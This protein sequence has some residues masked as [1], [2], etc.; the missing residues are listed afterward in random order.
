MFTI[1]TLLRLHVLDRVYNGKHGTINLLTSIQSSAPPSPVQIAR[2]QAAMEEA[3]RS[4]Q[5]ERSRFEADAKAMQAR[6]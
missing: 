6:S 2:Q 1:F 4:L 5:M 3:R